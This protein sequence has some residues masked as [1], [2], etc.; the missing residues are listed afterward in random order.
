MN[1]SPSDNDRLNRIAGKLIVV[2]IVLSFAVCG[3]F[4]YRWLL[5]FRDLARLA[6]CRPW[7]IL[8]AAENY[9]P[10]NNGLY[11]PL[12]PVAGRFVY[13][14]EKVRPYAYSIS[15]HVC[16]FDA[17]GP[18]EGSLRGVDLSLLDDWSYVYL[19]FVIEDE[20]QGLAF[21][22]AYTALAESTDNFDVDLTVTEGQ[23]NGGG[24]I[25][26]RLRTPSEFTGDLAYIGNNAAA[27]PVVIEWPGNHG[28][29][30]SKVVFLDGHEEVIPFPG[31]FPMT[32]RFISALRDLDRTF[33][34][35]TP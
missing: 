9:A 35:R 8:R 5:H 25:L 29:R 10:G 21:L 19:G 32:E 23:G 2:V 24:T 26:H 7:L 20:T 30:G 22:N 15:D 11:P 28:E 34:L 14:I 33:P 1:N 18:R 6:S 4:G 31:K 27:I 17:E 13:D 3:W 16:E 12:S